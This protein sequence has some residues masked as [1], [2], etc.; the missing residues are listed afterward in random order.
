MAEHQKMTS[1]E[2]MG[3][4]RGAKTTDEC[5]AATVKKVSATLMQLASGALAQL[6]QAAASLSMMLPS[7]QLLSSPAIR[8]RRLQLSKLLLKSPSINS[9]TTSDL[10]LNLPMNAKLHG[11]KKVSAMPML[12]ASGALAQL[13]QAAASLSLMLPS[14]H[15]PSSSATPKRRLQL[16]QKPLQRPS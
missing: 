16:F 13:S 8:R 7:F 3:V 14:S 15:P 10:V 5:K 12:I 9:T 1:H 2:F 11:A 4:L 6:S